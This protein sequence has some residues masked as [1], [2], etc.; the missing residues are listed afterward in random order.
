MPTTQRQFATAKAFADFMS[1]HRWGRSQV[2]FINRMSGIARIERVTN[3]IARYSH[4]AIEDGGLQ[5]EYD[6]AA[7]GL[8]WV[9]TS[10]RVN[11]E[12]IL[13]LREMTARR[14]CELIHDLM[15]Y[16]YNIGL[17]ATYLMGK[18]TASPQ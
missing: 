3:D 17:Y 13:A 7:F 14:L 12:T 2:L 5:F 9:I 10:G 4:W 11:G 8:M 1:T 15:A 16:H 6:Q 18:F